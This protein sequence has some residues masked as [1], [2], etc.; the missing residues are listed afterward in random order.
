MQTNRTEIKVNK[1]LGIKNNTYYFVDGLFQYEPE[2]K[3]Q[4]I[5]FKGCTLS[6]M[7]GMTGEQM[8]EK[9]D[10]YDRKDL[11]Q[12]NVAGNQTTQWLDEWIDDMS[13]EEKQ[14]IVRDESYED[15]YL[16]QMQAIDPEI[17]YTDCTG[18]G[19]GREPDMANADY[20]DE[21][22]GKSTFDPELAKLCQDA[23]AN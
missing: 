21:I 10:D 19:R 15:E 12:M 16:E 7:E 20:R 4:P 22:D 13:D 3:T 14:G 1:L 8:Q 18:W 23:E 9:I 2:D 11:R 17:M 5:T 6:Y